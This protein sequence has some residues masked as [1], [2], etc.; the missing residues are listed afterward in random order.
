MVAPLCAKFREPLTSFSNLGCSGPE[1]GR[2]TTEELATGFTGDDPG[3]FNITRDAEFNGAL[4]AKAATAGGFLGAPTPN[5][6][7]PCE[8][9]NSD[10]PLETIV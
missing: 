4:A 10:I 9:W 5:L 6:E 7:A 1:W 3:G 8:P 2:A